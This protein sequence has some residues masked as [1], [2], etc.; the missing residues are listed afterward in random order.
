MLKERLAPR[1]AKRRTNWREPLSVGLKI[2][3]TLRYLATDE[4]YI[5]LNYHFRTG[6]VTISKFVILVCKA[7]IGEF[8][9]EHL[10]YPTTPERWKEIET[11]FGLRWNVPYALDGN[12]WPSGS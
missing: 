4:T 12:M 8:M 3:I 1:L 2:A 5:S 10:T 11:E 9:G 6:K 7:I